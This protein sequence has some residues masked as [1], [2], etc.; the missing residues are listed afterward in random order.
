[1][2]IM[3]LRYWANNWAGL[4]LSLATSLGPF[5]PVTIY[6]VMTGPAMD[7]GAMSISLDNWTTTKTNKQLLPIRV[8]FRVF[9]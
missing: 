8:E 4:K 3:G 5:G 1:M 2:E 9:F 7:A 6:N